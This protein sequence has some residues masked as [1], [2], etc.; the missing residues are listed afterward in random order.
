MYRLFRIVP[1]R[2][3]RWNLEFQVQHSLSSSSL[4][5]H[6]NQWLLSWSG[7]DDLDVQLKKQRKEIATA[8]PNMDEDMVRLVN[9]LLQ[10]SD[11]WTSSERMRCYCAI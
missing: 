11:V 5:G 3:P 7:E 4:V 9:M 2:A 10:V 1:Q 8:K 6:S